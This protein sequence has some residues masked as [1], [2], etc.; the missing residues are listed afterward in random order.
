MRC[1]YVDGEIDIAQRR[2]GGTVHVQ[3]ACFGHEA[4]GAGDYRAVTR[5]DEG[6]RPDRELTVPLA[7]LGDADGSHLVRITPD[8]Y[9]YLYSSGEGKTYWSFAVSYPAQRGA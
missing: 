9:V 2:V 7:V 3:G 1:Y 8:G 4:T 5:L 6:Y